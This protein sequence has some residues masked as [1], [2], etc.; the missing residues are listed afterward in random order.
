MFAVSSVGSGVQQPNPVYQPINDGE[1]HGD[2]V[3]VN[4]I[5][6]PGIHFDSADKN[7]ISLP[8]EYKKNDLING[9]NYTISGWI[10]LESLS[11]KQH[12]V[13]DHSYKYSTPSLFVTEEGTPIFRVHWDRDSFDYSVQV[14]GQQGQIQ[15]GRWYHITAVSERTE[16]STEIAIFIDGKKQ[17]STAIDK[18]IDY[19]EHFDVGY[20]RHNHQELY[21]NGVI[22]SFDVFDRV[23]EEDQIRSHYSSSGT[24]KYYSVIYSSDFILPLILVG[25]AIG[26]AFIETRVRS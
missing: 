17:D 2:P 20:G 7:Y 19:A 24:S 25:F 14:T 10:K 13:G 11:Q 8:S 22:S 5:N 3:I 4:G 21:F 1:L 6:G 9:G 26:T 15:P 18:E 16:Q 23:L 12:I